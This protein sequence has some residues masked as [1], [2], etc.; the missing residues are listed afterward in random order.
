MLTHVVLFKFKDGNKEAILKSKEML[1]GLFGVVPEL[2]SIEVGVDVLRSERSYDLSLITT[3]DS[4]EA[5]KAYQ[6]HPAHDEVAKY[7]ATVK[8]SSIAVDYES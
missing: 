6:V 7:I 3:F 5:M 2:K 1:E 8:E 4:M